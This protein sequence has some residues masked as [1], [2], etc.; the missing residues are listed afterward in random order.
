MGDKLDTCDDYGIWYKSTLASR[1]TD[2]D[3]LDCDGKPI[4]MLH[5]VCRYADPEGQ[6]VKDGVKVTG[7]LKDEFDLILEVNSIAVRQFESYSCQYYNVG[8]DDMKYD[9]D[10]TD[11]EDQLFQTEELVQFANARKVQFFGGIK[12]F[13]TMIDDFGSAGG[14]GRILVLFD[15]IKEGLYKISV[16]HISLIVTFLANTMPFWTRE[17]MCTE[18]G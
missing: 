9:L 5:I 11:Q 8:N 13:A 12:Y 18:I 17:F 1:Y 3:N 2:E 14:F 10:V 16:E 15:Q 7:W 6:K 4:E